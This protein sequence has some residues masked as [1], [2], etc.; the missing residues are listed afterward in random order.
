M[1]GSGGVPHDG[2]FKRLVLEVKWCAQ[3]LITYV[4]Q[5]SSRMIWVGVVKSRVVSSFLVGIYCM[6]ELHVCLDAV[7]C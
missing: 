5:W 1:S 3:A 2:W 4:D 6:N 7:I